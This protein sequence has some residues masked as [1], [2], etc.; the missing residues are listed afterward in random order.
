MV[1]TIGDRGYVIWELLEGLFILDVLYVHVFC[2]CFGLSL[3]VVS[4]LFEGERE[5]LACS[6]AT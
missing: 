3:L 2:I 4:W 1:Q 5:M 6:E